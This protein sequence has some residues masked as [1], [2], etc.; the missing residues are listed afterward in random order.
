MSTRVPHPYGNFPHYYHS[1]N[2][3]FSLDPR[4][5]LLPCSLFTS[6]RVLD[7]GCN[8]GTV[9]LQVGAVLQP[10]EIVGVDLDY[11]LVN[12]A[13]ENWAQME[14][15]HRKGLEAKKLLE[16]IEDLP[17]S[18]RLLI[19]AS[20]DLEALQKLQESSGG[21]GFPSNVNFEVREV[22]TEGLPEGQ[23]DTILCLST[24]KWI[25]LNWGDE[26]LKSL[27][28]CIHKSLSPMGHLVLEPQ[29]W[30]SYKKLRN[31]S[32]RFRTH[33]EKIELRPQLLPEYL[34]SQGFSLVSQG[35]PES[36]DVKERFL[37]EVYVYQ[38]TEIR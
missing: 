32:L 7:I 36:E 12:K 24:V 27:F 22:V 21:V 1:R 5:S 20:G 29:P 6:K 14:V 31:Q 26:G 34:A 16:E 15:L 13:V 23:F 3:T 37:R 11:Q 9:T 30:S 4:L 18:Y 2:S 17:L 35:V 33:Y 38:K 25:Q 28:R 19:Q 8:D 10:R